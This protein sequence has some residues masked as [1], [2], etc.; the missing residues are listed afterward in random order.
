MQSRARNYLQVDQHIKHNFEIPT[1]LARPTEND[2]IRL[3]T[4]QAIQPESSITR[5]DLSRAFEPVAEPEKL[6]P[7]T[8]T[9]ITEDLAPYIRS[10]MAYDGRLQQERTKLSNLLSEGGRPGKKLR[11]TR[12]AM[13][14]LEGGARKT[15]RRDRWF[16]GKVN[17]YHVMRTGMQS[18]FDAAAVDASKRAEDLT[19]NSAASPEA[20][21]DDTC[22]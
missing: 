1:E 2:V 3:I 15:T 9:L 10:I 22:E 8:T 12:A 21:S 7:L 17:T 16:T 18:W 4:A 5:K 6:W 19:T 14:A 20:T 13:S 11:T